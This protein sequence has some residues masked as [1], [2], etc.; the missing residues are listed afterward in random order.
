MVTPPTLPA[1]TRQQE[2]GM[3][4]AS[5]KQERRKKVGR[6]EEKAAERKPKEA[7]RREEGSSQNEQ[8]NR[9]LEST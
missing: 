4:K 7:E 9:N 8:K 3:R 2:E 5:W 1:Y 6:K